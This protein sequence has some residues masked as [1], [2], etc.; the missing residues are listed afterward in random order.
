[1]AVKLEKRTV[2][3]IKSETTQNTAIALGA[4]DYIRAEDVSIEPVPENLVRNYYRSTLGPLLTV[5]G[6]MYYKVGLKTELKG[7]GAAGTPYAPLGAIFK[8]AG[9]LETITGGTSVVYA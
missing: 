9:W 6:R 4:T 7:G 1:M 2:I 5:P 3:G 8:M